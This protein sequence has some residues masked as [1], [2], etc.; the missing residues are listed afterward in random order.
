MDAQVENPHLKLLGG[1]SMPR[2]EF[3]QLTARQTR[4]TART[5]AWSADFPDL[6]LADYQRMNAD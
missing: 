5:G 6:E 3:I 4:K 1:K 2:G